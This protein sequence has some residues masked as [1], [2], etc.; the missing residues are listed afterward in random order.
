MN[1]SGPGIRTSYSAGNQH[2][3]LEKTR[4][5]RARHQFQGVGVP[6]RPLSDGRLENLSGRRSQFIRTDTESPQAIAVTL[7]RWLAY[8]PGKAPFCF[9]GSLDEIHIFEDALRLDQITDLAT[10]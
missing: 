3:A 2:G 9:R 1:R 4:A 5:V 7:G 8:Q 6:F 10:P